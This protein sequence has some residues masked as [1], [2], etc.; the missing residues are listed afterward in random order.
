MFSAPILYPIANIAKPYQ[1]WLYLNT[2]TWVV[3]TWRHVMYWGIWPNWSQWTMALGVGLVFSTF[4]A[5][6]FERL[7]KGFADV[8]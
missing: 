6:V 3:E 8:L 2:L 4:G 5:W 7:K 1:I